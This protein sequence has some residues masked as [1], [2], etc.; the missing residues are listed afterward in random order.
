LTT[1]AARPVNA[2]LLVTRACARRS[3]RA[4]LLRRPAQ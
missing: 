3:L 1:L 4:L 2:T